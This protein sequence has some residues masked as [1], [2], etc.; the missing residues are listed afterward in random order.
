[1]AQSYFRPV[2]DALAG[3]TPG[4]QPKIQNLIKLNTNENPYPPAPG[5]ADVLRN[6]DLDRMRRY[7]DPW[8]RTH[9]ARWWKYYEDAIHCLSVN[10]EVRRKLAKI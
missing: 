6:I 8:S 10:P 1:M 2:I 5:V 7:P 4:E 3:Y 9:S